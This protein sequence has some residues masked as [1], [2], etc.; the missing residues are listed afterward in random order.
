MIPKPIKDASLSTY[1]QIINDGIKEG[2]EQGIEQGAITAV[3]NM[4]ED[5]VPDMTIAKYL[6][7]SQDFIDDVRG[8][9]KK[10]KELDA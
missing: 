4:I 10:P 5:K 3:R 8:N 2:L 1:Q 6:D 9:L 7:V